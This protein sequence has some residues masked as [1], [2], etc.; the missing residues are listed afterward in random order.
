MIYRADTG[1]VET[2]KLNDAGTGSTS[3]WIGSWTTGWS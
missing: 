3:L 1:T 2:R